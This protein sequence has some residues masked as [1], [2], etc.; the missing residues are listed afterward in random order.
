MWPSP[1]PGAPVD[2]RHARVVT[3]LV[4]VPHERAPAAPPRG[5]FLLLGALTGL[6]P[7]AIDAYLPALPS[8]T[9][10][11]QTTSSATQLTLA[12][13]LVGLATGQLVAGSYSDRLGRRSPALAGL[14]GFVLASV[15]CALAPSVEVLIGVR[16]VQGFAG[17]AAVV[18]ARAIVRDLYGGAAAARAYASLMLVMGAA[19]ILAPVVGAQVLR[20]TSWRGV[21]V[22]LA[23]LGLL[24]LAATARSLPETLP[25]ERRTAGGLGVTLQIFG[26]LA[27]DPGFVLP[28][29][30]G[31]AAFAAMFAYISG[32]PYVLQQVHGLSPQLYSLV[33]A[34]N[35]ATLIVLSQVSGRLVARTGP[36]ALLLTGAVVSVV[37]ASLLVVSALA[38]L[39]LAGVLPALVLVVGAVGLVS[40]NATALALAD[41]GRTAGAAQRAAGPAAVR[42]RCGGCSAHRARRQPHR[43]ADGAD[44]RWRLGSGAALRARLAG[45]APDL[46][47]ASR[48]VS[49]GDSMLRAQPRTRSARCAGPATTQAATTWQRWSVRS[50][51]V[52]VG[53]CSTSSPA[54]RTR[55]WRTRSGCSSTACPSSSSPGCRR[56]R[57]PPFST[58]PA[59]SCTAASCPSRGNGSSS[60][61]SCSRS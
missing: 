19:P 47:A 39:G 56:W 28:S 53:S 21:F 60:T 57:R 22:V 9:R 43:P 51:A 40:P 44:D 31:G 34:G 4:H 5:R 25:P 42:P 29:L 48:E 15:G 33:F 30:A 37:G 8:L 46:T 11:L 38:D 18:V 12:A 49:E 23:L 14:F 17:A 32:S 35:A 26:R 45:R 2:A 27:R 13:L 61:G 36:L 1:T 6:T 58:G 3:T 52:T 54:V 24:L 20:L 59:T 16:F 55:L 50:S 7:F 10:D 41:H